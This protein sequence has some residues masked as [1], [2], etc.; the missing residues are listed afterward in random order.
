MTKPMT[1]WQQDGVHFLLGLTLALVFLG[2]VIAVAGLLFLLFSVL[3]PASLR[4][5]MHS[6]SRPVQI[7]VLAITLVEVIAWNL[8]PLIG[9][10]SQ[11]LARRMAVAMAAIMLFMTVSLL[12]SL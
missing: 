12:F 4:E 3:V 9:F 5:V 7:G 1:N 2:A 8:L 6:L 10:A 11:K